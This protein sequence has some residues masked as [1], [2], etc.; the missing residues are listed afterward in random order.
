MLKN[1][2]I[3]LALLAGIFVFYIYYVGWFS[4]YLLLLTLCMPVLSLLLSLPGMRGLSLSAQMPERCERGDSAAVHISRTSRSWLPTPLYSF[5]LTVTDR[6]SG[7]ENVHR[8]LLSDGQAGEAGLPAE[9]CGFYS[10]QLK[11]GRVYDYLGLF[12]FRLKLPELPDFWV[13]PKPHPPAELP[14]LSQ[15]QSR[16]YRPKRGGGFS[17]IHDMREYLPGDS[18]RDIHWKLSAKTDKLIVRE[19]QEPNRGMVLLSLDLAGT[20]DQLDETFDL[21]VWLSTWLLNHET[22]HSVCWLNPESFEPEGAAI[23]SEE[24]LRELLRTLMKTRLGQDTPSISERP[25]PH[26]DW[27]YHIRPSRQEAAS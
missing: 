20:R 13:E 2:L 18:M 17:E 23:A 25:F 10:C 3:Y 9:H 12:S 6:M 5:R 26:A 22:A 11:R 4:W 19:P 7:E 15:F 27:R 8:I 1:R 16:S 24:D 21:L 14:N